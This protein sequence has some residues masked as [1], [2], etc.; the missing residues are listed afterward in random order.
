MSMLD[1]V[2]QNPIISEHSAQGLQAIEHKHRSCIRLTI[3]QPECSVNL[4]EAYKARESSANRWDYYLY[5]KKAHSSA[6]VFFEPHTC[7][8]KEVSCFLAKF[9]WLKM[10]LVDQL[11]FLIKGTKKQFYFWI[12]SSGNK[13]NEHTPQ[14]KRLQKTKIKIRIVKVIQDYDLNSI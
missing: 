9:D 12:P 7:T 5:V 3:Y 2:E 1:Q 4:D 13:I 8:T 14:Y 6:A 10:K 11:S